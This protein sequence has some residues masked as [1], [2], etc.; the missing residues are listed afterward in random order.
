VK[1]T[2]KKFLWPG[3]ALILT[4]GLIHTIDA[5][6]SFAVTASENLPA[7]PGAEGFGRFSA[8][9]R[10][11]VV[12]KVT[13]LSD[14]GAGS[15]RAC[16]EAS[17]PRVCVFE[18]SGTISLN[19]MVRIKN[20]YI[21]IA[22]Q[23]AP[24][25]GIFIRYNDIGIRTHDVIIRHIS[26]GP[27]DYHQD[28]GETLFTDA[29]GIAVHGDSYN[30]MIDHVSIFFGIDQVGSIYLNRE[31]APHDV[32]ISNSIAAYPLDCS[33]HY[34]GGCHAKGILVGPGS[35]RISLIKNIIAHSQDRNPKFTGTTHG[36]AINNIVYNWGRD[37]MEFGQG[38]PRF[39]NSR[40]GG[41]YKNLPV[42]GAAVGNIFISGAD[43]KLNQPIS[44]DQITTATS[45]LYLADNRIDGIAPADQWSRAMVIYRKGA[46]ITK[47]ASWEWGS[48]ATL[49]PSSQVESYCLAHAGS[50]P[51][52]R[53]P[54]MEQRIANNITSK[55]GQIIDCVESSTCSNSFGGWPVYAE[56]HRK[57][58]VPASDKTIAAKSGYTVLE[59]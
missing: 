51:K 36:E 16:A 52:D 25:P 23:T 8:G 58:A 30:V 14:S 4:I 49:L 32:T 33:M 24:S 46:T 44:V 34:E 53:H 54:E 48:G 38:K 40:I 50:R 35:E 13:N 45:T 10:G 2:S 11:G 9:G 28:T 29:D 47:S 55:T 31:G 39:G 37:S 17:G 20:P 59:E 12:Y 41:Q 5:K 19:S 27:G 42:H 1:D 6:D 56:N 57:L 15:L 18:V 21:T 43:T 7:F 3:I 22:G 26:V